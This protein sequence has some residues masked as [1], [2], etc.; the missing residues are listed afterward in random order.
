MDELEHPVRAGHRLPWRRLFWSCFVIASLLATVFA[1]RLV[2]ERFV[3]HKLD[4][5]ASEMCAVVDQGQ[6]PT[7]TVALLR[8]DLRIAGL[9]LLPDP[10]C[11]GAELSI[12]GRLDTLDVSGLSL[13]RLVFGGEIVLDR[14]LVR[15]DGLVVELR[16]DRAIS[17]TQKEPE[18]RTVRVD[19]FDVHATSTRF[20]HRSDDTLSLAVRSVAVSGSNVHFNTGEDGPTSSRGCEQLLLVLDSL[21]ALTSTG[22][23]AAFGR[24]ALDQ[25]TETFA[26]HCLSIG[27]TQGLE[28]HSTTMR[29][30]GDVYQA[31]LDTLT[32]R[33]LDVELL[34]AEGVCSISG[35]SISYGDIGVLRDK[36]LPDGPDPIKPLLARVLRGLPL[37][38]GVDTIS[39]NGVDISY[40]ERSTRSRGYAR[41]PFN[42][43]N[44]TI[45]GARNSDVDTARLTIA[46]R[47]LAFESAPVE[48]NFS[49]LIND[50]TDHFDVSA[51][52]GALP[53][54]KL[55]Q[56][57]GPLANIRATEGLMDSLVFHMHADDLSGYGT[58]RM[59]YEG[60]K[61][62]NGWRRDGDLMIDVKTALLNTLV[63]DRNHEKDGVTRPAKYTLTR[64]RNRSFFNYL[65]SGLREGVKA[66]LL[67]ETLSGQEQ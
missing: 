27:P 9:L 6:P 19:R 3:R 30:E 38:S 64:L 40:Q 25:G 44:A 15:A 48:L 53:F 56:A 49:S 36:T 45:I 8:G 34:L 52:I 47:C 60:L 50:T 28:Q 46:A 17:N 35:L 10:T 22:Y 4:S 55:N 61:L 20:V 39:L 37:N 7:I 18:A 57:T 33:G 16:K 63:R 51:R 43:V 66:A 21:V 14:L 24:V 13:L 26:L 65:W 29:F 67:P 31:R 23:E 32:G 5:L 59:T 2:A 54:S 41:I 11:Q 58:V 62:E 42:G 12:E 1:L